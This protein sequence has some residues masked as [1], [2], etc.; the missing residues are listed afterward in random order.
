MNFTQSRS[1]SRS[2]LTVIC[3]AGAI[4]FGSAE[5]VGVPDSASWVQLSTRQFSSSALVSCDDLRS[6]QRQNNH[7]SWIRWHRLSERHVDI[8]RRYLGTGGVSHSP[9]VRAAAQMAYSSVT[10]KV[11]L[12]RRIVRWNKLPGRHVV[13]GW[14]NLAVDTCQNCASPCACNWSYAVFGSERQGRSFLADLTDISTNSRSG[15]GPAPIGR[16]YFLERS[17]LHA[18]Q[19][20]SRQILLL[21]R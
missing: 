12:L 10:R 15:N 4:A 6:S 20:R 21:T 5:S 19:R 8:R 13:V 7:V 1:F 3:C 18:P 9:P 17:R 16:N 11:V 2:L 14:N